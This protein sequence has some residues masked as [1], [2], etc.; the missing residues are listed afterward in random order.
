LDKLKEETLLVK[1]LTQREQSALSEHRELA[2]RAERA[3]KK[4]KVNA[5]FHLIPRCSRRF[6]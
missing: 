6:F 1:H 5:W 3:E 2:A 4:S